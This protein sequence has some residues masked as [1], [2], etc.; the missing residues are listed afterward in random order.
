VSYE[1]WKGRGYGTPFDG[2]DGRNTMRREGGRREGEEKDS[3]VVGEG[4][5]EDRGKAE[6]EDNFEALVSNSLVKGSELGITLHPLKEGGGKGGRDGGREGGS[7]G[8]WA[9]TKEGGG[10]R[11]REESRCKGGKEGGVKGWR[12]GGREGG[13]PSPQST[14]GGFGQ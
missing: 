11:G 2:L 10:K 14:G 8:W 13:L 1:W 12:E 4:E 7:D 6:E 3:H 5:R 9:C